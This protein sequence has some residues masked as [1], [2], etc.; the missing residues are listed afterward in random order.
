MRSWRFY[1]SLSFK[2]VKDHACCYRVA[3]GIYDVPGWIL[4]S[5]CSPR[6]SVGQFTPAKPFPYLRMAQ[7]ILAEAAR[8]LVHTSGPVGRMIFGAIS[9]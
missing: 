5:S 4:V 7:R 9:R 8:E 1:P 6:T 2:I 3:V